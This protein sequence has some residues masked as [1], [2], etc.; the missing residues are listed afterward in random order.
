M[1]ESQNAST[2]AYI[3]AVVEAIDSGALK[4]ND[5]P[6]VCHE[7]GERPWE[8]DPHHDVHGD[9]VVVACE[10]YWQIDP[11]LIG[12]PRDGWSAPGE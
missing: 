12:W 7:C 1:N 10:G 8:G 11:A 3:T 4:A 6:K 5:L 2:G 9:I